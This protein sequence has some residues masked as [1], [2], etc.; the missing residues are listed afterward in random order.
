MQYS[1]RV[2]N[3]NGSVRSN[4]MSTSM[5]MQMI[6]DAL[7]LVYHFTFKLYFA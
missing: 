7:V 4:Q 2:N 5:P 6:Q 1:N 3:R